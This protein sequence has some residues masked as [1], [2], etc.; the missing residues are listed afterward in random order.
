[1]RIGESE[2]KEWRLGLTYSHFCSEKITALRAEQMRREHSADNATDQRG[3][4]S[5]WGV[6]GHS[7]G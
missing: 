4:N 1:M 7:R 3:G 2:R 6:D 5:G